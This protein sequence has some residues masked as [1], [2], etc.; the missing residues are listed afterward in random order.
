MLLEFEDAYR[1]W[2]RWHEWLACQG[3]EDLRP[4]GILR[5]NQ[6]DQTIHAALAGQGVALGRL[7]LIG[8]MLADRRLATVTM[9]HPGPVTQN[10]FWLIRSSSTARPE[11]EEVICWIREEA[12][13][14]MST[15][16]SVARTR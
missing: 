8:M 15:D 16:A 11:V 6:Y 5:F 9:P 3:W 12:E 1:P 14:V 10:G 4:R 13:K 7:E 2:L